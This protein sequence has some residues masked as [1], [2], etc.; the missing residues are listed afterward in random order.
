MRLELGGEMTE[1]DDGFTWFCD[2]HGNR[3][4]LPTSTECDER[5][6]NRRNDLEVFFLE[7]SN[8]LAVSRSPSMEEWAH[9]SC[10]ALSDA[11]DRFMAIK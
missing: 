10:A 11:Y 1:Q 9:A 6:L 2:T 3:K 5:I 4:R 7:L 8:W